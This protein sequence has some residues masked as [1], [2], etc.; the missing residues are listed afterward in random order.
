MKHRQVLSFHRATRRVAGFGTF[1]ARR[2]GV[3]ASVS[4]SL[5]SPRFF[6]K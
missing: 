2:G 1:S 6:I 4:Q 5:C 3:V